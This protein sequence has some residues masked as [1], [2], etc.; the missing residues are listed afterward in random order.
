MDPVHGS[1]SSSVPTEGS[2]VGLAPS[3]APFCQE[4]KA[5]NCWCICNNKLFI[6]FC[7]NNK[8]AVSF[9]GAPFLSFS[10]LQRAQRRYTNQSNCYVMA[11]LAKECQNALFAARLITGGSWR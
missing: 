2:S 4:R 3:P 1:S 8:L 5:R 11:A 10:A 7:C 9:Q 6:N